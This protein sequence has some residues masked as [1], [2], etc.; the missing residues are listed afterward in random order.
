MWGEI[1]KIEKPKKSRNEG[2]KFIRVHFKLKN[3]KW[4]KVDLVPTFRNFARWEPLLKVGNFID[5][6]KFKDKKTVDADCFPVLRTRMDLSFE[7]EKLMK[8]SEQ[9]L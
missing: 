6:L 5:N 7:D 2:T 8:L 4:A 3:K 9:C 1:I